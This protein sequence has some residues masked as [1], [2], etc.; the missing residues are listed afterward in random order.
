ME[1]VVSQQNLDDILRR[2]LPKDEDK[3]FLAR[4]MAHVPA[5]RDR[6][7][8][9]LSA[10]LLITLG[11]IEYFVPG[12]I[13]ISAIDKIVYFFGQSV[14]GGLALAAVFFSW[15]LVEFIRR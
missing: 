15:V 13:F 9:V 3:E 8:L 10:V 6:S 12:R 1:V 5:R 14:E 7:V 4:V 2:P 11:A